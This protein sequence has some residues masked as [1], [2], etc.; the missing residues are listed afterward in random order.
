MGGSGG[1]SAEGGGGRGR[2]RGSPRRTRG[3]PWAEPRGR[4]G[5]SGDGRGVKGRDLPAPSAR[6]A[7]PRVAPAPHRRRGRICSPATPRAEGRQSVLGCG[8]AG[9]VL[10]IQ[11]SLSHAPAPLRAGVSRME[12]TGSS[13]RE[14]TGRGVTAPFLGLLRRRVTPRYFPLKKS[15]V[16]ITITFVPASKAWG[17]S[18]AREGVPEGQPVK[19]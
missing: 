19:V 10:R 15:V 8:S 7:A 14:P 3:G 1:R 12:G 18:G 16:I 5:P 17:C 4:R 13:T 2:W 11:K 6:P 9:R